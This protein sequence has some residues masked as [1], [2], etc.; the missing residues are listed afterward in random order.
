MR[1]D[2]EPKSLKR[3][4]EILSQHLKV[5]QMSLDDTKQKLKLT[6]NKPKPTLWQSLKILLSS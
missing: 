1:S 2:F 3:A 6:Q 5:A 4:N